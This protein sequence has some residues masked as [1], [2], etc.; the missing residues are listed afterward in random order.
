[1]LVLKKEMNK[2]NN[3]QIYTKTGTFHLN[4][5]TENQDVVMH[6]EN[7]EY[8]IISLADGVSSCKN[9]KE[10]ANIACKTVTDIFLSC[11]HIFLD[12]PREKTAYLVLSEIA[13][14]IS[15]AARKS[16]ETAESYSSTIC[17][18]CIEKETGRMLSF[19]LGDSN[20]YLLSET[21]CRTMSSN[22]NRKPVFTTYKDADEQAL[23]NI[24]DIKKL[25]GV[26][27]CSDGAWQLLHNKSIFEPNLLKTIQRGDFSPLEKFFENKDNVD[28]CSYILVDFKDRKIA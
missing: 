17:F 14:N 11:G 7:D 21:G 15:A 25:N 2:I 26:M 6:A 3:I 1:M 10:G 27:L 8:E 19:Q 20:L 23:V 28:D 13:G 4:N 5:N 16:G 12:Y 22:K 24:Y 9:G 18:A